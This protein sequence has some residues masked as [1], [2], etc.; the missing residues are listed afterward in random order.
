MTT[1]VEQVA[2]CSL[3]GRR[4]DAANGGG[5]LLYDYCLA[6]GPMPQAGG[7]Q[8]R[9]GGLLRQKIAG[10]SDPAVRAGLFPS[11]TTTS[12]KLTLS[13]HV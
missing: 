13:K 1:A 3:R 10:G 6:Q 2:A 7:K 8:R 11:T 9:K 12:S 5:T 4:L